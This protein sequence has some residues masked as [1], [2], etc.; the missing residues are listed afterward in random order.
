MPRRPPCRWFRR[1]VED[2]AVA[3]HAADPAAVC[4]AAWRRKSKRQKAETIAMEETMPSRPRKRE[5]K[6][7]LHGAALEA[8]KK[9]H[10]MRS[11]THKAHGHAVHH[12]AHARRSAARHPERGHGHKATGRHHHKCP[13]CGHAAL[14]DRKAGCLHFD[15]KR[16]CSCQ[17]R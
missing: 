1:C 10:G 12:G 3:G 17:H 5:H 6:G 4:G 14:H 8:W 15:G 7:K 11:T 13:Y 16:F 9:K 2:V